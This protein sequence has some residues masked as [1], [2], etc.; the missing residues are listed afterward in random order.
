MS[1]HH[2]QID[3]DRRNYLKALGAFGVAGITGVA[4]CLDDGGQS[5]TESGDGK[6]LE[7]VHGWTGD[8][9]ESAVAAL[10]S[11]YEEKHSDVSKKFS[12]V[13]AS[14]NVE[15]NSR[16][17]QRIRNDNAMSVFANWPGANLQRYKGYLMDVES[18]WDDAGLKDTIHEATIEQ[19]KFNGKIPGV[20]I[21][22]HRMNNL[23]VNISL[24]EQAGVDYT[25]IDSVEK[26]I[27]AYDTIKSET[28]AAPMGQAMKGPWTGLQ[29]FA[30]I[31]AS[32]SGVEAYQ[33]FIDGSPDGAAIRE[34]LRA[35]KTIHENHITDDAS[36]IGFTDANQK[37]ISDK[38][39]SIHQGNWAYGMY[40]KDDGFNFKEEWD[41]IPFP[42][43]EEMYF[44]HLDSF[45]V[46][47]NTPTPELAKEFLTFAGSKEAQLAFNK[48]KGSVPLRTDIDAN[49]LPE[50]LKITYNDLLEAESLPPTIAHGLAV[51]P[52]TAGACKKAFNSNFMDPYDVEATAT[53][54]EEAVS[55]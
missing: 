13:G 45:I 53:A 36:T 50:F 7:V 4:G 15:L 26:L 30:Q 11:A 33:S 54:L 34:A 37:V 22:S 5:S 40:R 41:W 52:E 51:T 24:F 44:F 12:A 14:A 29:L 42:G 28:D 31:L 17:T 23:F 48:N 47:E 39:A 3:D 16:V 19:H 2:P 35:Q 6:T 20:P 32:Q 18:V 9:G 1:D 46:P 21:G 43:T 27:S 49:E 25:S 10:E 38:A 8:D 55:N